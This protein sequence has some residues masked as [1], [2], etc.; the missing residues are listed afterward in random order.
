MDQLAAIRVFVRVAERGSFTRAADDLQLSRAVVSHHVASLE[1]HLGVR[2][3]GRTTRRVTPTQDGLD[4]L[5]RMRGVMA[6]LDAADEAARH[7]R[8]R[9]QGKLRADVPTTFGQHLLLPALPRFLERYPGLDLDLRLND[10]IVD[11]EAERVDVVVRGGVV[12]SPGLIAKVIARPW[13]VT[14]AS[15]EYL[16]RHGVPLRPEDLAHH[17]LLG[18]VNPV[19]GRPRD[20]VLRIGGRDTP[21]KLDFRAVFDTTEAPVLAAIAG[22]GLCHTVDLLVSRAIAEGQLQQVLAAH[23]LRAAPISVVYPA[24]QRGSA[25]VKVFAEFAA[26]LMRKFD[27]KLHGTDAP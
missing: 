26:E 12:D 3:L 13:M 8:E 20:W 22:G 23:A 10:R 4:Y 1:K 15:P 14:C 17:Q 27:G 7:G 11:L 25:K 16:A 21:L 24:S 2:L 6:A 19:T 9:P 5:E 18:L